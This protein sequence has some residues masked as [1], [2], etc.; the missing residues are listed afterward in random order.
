MTTATRI[1]ITA[2]RATKATS[3]LAMFELF[4]QPVFVKLAQHT[5]KRVG[6]H[7]TPKLKFPCTKINSIGLSFLYNFLG[8]K[9]V[10]SIVYILSLTLPHTTCTFP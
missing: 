2:Q 7:T 9:T 8:I 6:H 5:H 3:A 10:G 1:P 4:D